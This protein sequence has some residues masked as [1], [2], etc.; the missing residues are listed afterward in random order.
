MQNFLA[1]R[2]VLSNQKI[3]T[4]ETLPIFNSSSVRKQWQS[5]RI[6]V[7][8]AISPLPKPTL[9]RLQNKICPQLCLGWRRINVGPGPT[10]PQHLLTTD[11]LKA[12]L[13]V[14]FKDVF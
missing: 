2:I 7:Q 8:L 11:F 9:M 10:W 3:V 12:F 6:V 1:I 5:L 14:W 4:K 13:F